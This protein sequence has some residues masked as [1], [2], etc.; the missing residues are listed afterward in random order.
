MKVSNVVERVKVLATTFVT[1]AVIASAT[2]SAALV[3][4]EPYKDVEYV[5]VAIK[6]G[7]VAVSALAVAV[8]IVRRVTPVP[9]VERGVLPVE[10][11]AS[12]SE[13]GTFWS[14]R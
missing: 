6:W 14:A 13:Q 2:I 8:A 4:L 12:V 3:E 9:E 7:G 11:S 1:W 5:G 10:R